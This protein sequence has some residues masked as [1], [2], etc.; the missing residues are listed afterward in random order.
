L[1]H[2]NKEQTVAVPAGNQ[3]LLRDELTTERERLEPFG[4]SVIKLAE[5]DKLSDRDGRDR[6]DDRSAADK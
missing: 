1:N 5:A 4:V 6:K 2:T 3:E